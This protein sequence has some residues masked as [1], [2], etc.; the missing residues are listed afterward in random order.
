LEAIAALFLDKNSLV[1]EDNMATFFALSQAFMFGHEDGLTA[2]MSVMFRT[3]WKTTYSGKCKARLGLR[4]DEAGNWIDQK[5]ARSCVRLYIAHRPPHY[6]GF[7]L[8]LIG[9]LYRC[10][11]SDPSAFISELDL[12]PD[13][14]KS[15][16]EAAELIEYHAE[17]AGGP[18]AFSVRITAELTDFER[19]YLGLKAVCQTNAA[20]VRQ[21]LSEWDK[22]I[23][24]LDDHILTLVSAD[25]QKMEGFVVEELTACLTRL[26]KFSQAGHV[27]WDYLWNILTSARAP[28]H[29]AAIGEAEEL[30]RDSTAVIGSVPVKLTRSNR[31]QV[32]GQTWAS[33]FAIPCECV[34]RGRKLLSKL[35]LSHGTIYVVIG[36]SS[37]SLKISEIETM[38]TRHPYGLQFFTITG[39][40]MLLK[41]TEANFGI[42]L[43][44]LTKLEMPNLISAEK[45][46][47]KGE[48]IDSD[49][50]IHSRISNYEYILYLNN[51]SG[52]NFLDLE[53][54]PVF[55]WLGEDRDLS[56]TVE[57]DL[58]YARRPMNIETAL[59]F[60]S[61]PFAKDV[62]ALEQQ[63][64]ASGM[65]CVPEIFAM[66]EFSSLETVYS[67]RKQLESPEV[68]ARLHDW[69]TLIWSVDFNS[70]ITPLFIGRHPKKVEHIDTKRTIRSITIS[71][72]MDSAIIVSSPSGFTVKFICYT[73]QCIGEFT[74]SSRDF[75]K[76]VPEVQ[77]IPVSLPELSQNRLRVTSTLQT[78]FMF[79]D[80]RSPTLYIL[81]TKTAKLT[82]LDVHR[83][84]ISSITAVGRWL[85]VGGENSEIVV[86]RDLAK[87][88][89]PFLYRDSVSAC[90]ISDIF[91]VVV[92]GIQDGSIVICS[93]LNRAIVHALTISPHV[94]R[95]I[96][97][98]PLWGFIVV[99]SELVVPGALDHSIWV[100]TINGE[101]VRDLQIPY[102]VE[103]WCSWT[104]SHGF[105]FVAIGTD[106]GEILMAE[107][108]Y[109][110]SLTCIYKF[111]DRIVAIAYIKEMSEI[112][113]VS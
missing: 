20:V 25:L 66:P 58:K 32:G 21:N 94:P 34:S 2:A 51:A 100:Y 92:P 55:P 62:V 59:E 78:S 76:I 80:P 22:S 54:Y 74:L 13:K 41:F 9:F 95:A 10:R 36:S 8:I 91:K 24:P 15:L 103:S 96:L 109:I 85:V 83:E 46:A 104:S 17:M 110:E 1:T 6:L 108:Y 35:E 99:Y 65:E 90:A 106:N 11:N 29:S 69:I 88:W 71:E 84:L 28:W 87:F 48:Q 81:P 52:R 50:W 26:K 5:L 19:L 57:G 97:V 40:T 105:D 102:T 101:T 12:P 70:G 23:P 67:L 4:F 63:S 45:L 39:A 82:T 53:Q 18:P 89:D 49:P 68:S 38:I 72:R 75:K 31:V 113:A 86:Y 107:V 42:F 61:P 16:G 37:L 112:L 73:G 79:F 93:L 64:R 43:A 47:F 60:M 77:K 98:T 14:V 111:P 56:R 33:Y 27:A 30:V 3:Y 7:T 44:E